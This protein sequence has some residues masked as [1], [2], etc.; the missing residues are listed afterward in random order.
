MK[1][2]EVKKPGYPSMART[3]SVRKK[4]VVKIRWDKKELPGKSDLISAD[5]VYAEHSQSCQ[6][7]LI[8][9]DML[10]SERHRDHEI[11]LRNLVK[12]KELTL[13]IYDPETLATTNLLALLLCR[14]LNYSEAFVMYK[15][16]LAACILLGSNNLNYSSYDECKSTALNNLGCILMKR[17]QIR[18]ATEHFDEALTIRSRSFADTTINCDNIAHNQGNIE[19]MKNNY[20][21]AAALYQDVLPHR[22][23]VSESRNINLC[24]TRRSFADSLYRAGKFNEAEAVYRHLLEDLTLIV[25]VRHVSLLL[26]E[27]GLAYTLLQQG[28]SVEAEAVVRNML[29]A[30]RSTVETD[31]TSIEE[32]ASILSI[33]TKTADLL[34]KQ[35]EY[36]AAEKLY[37][38]ILPH[39]QN[40]VSDSIARC[41]LEQGNLVG[42]CN[43]YEGSLKH[44]EECYGNM[45]PV[46]L[47]AVT[48]LGDL[49]SKSSNHDGALAC[50]QRA[51]EAYTKE[52]GPDNYLTLLALDNSGKMHEKLNRLYDAQISFTASLVG[53]EKTLGNNNDNQ[54]NAL[55]HV[56]NVRTVFIL[57]SHSG[58]RRGRKRSLVLAA[59][60]RFTTSFI[61]III[62]R[63]I[64]DFS[65]IIRSIFPSS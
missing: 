33:M 26:C 47:F 21:A 43:F 56:H 25:G 65:A 44:R 52:L 24:D 41:R 13:G 45:H 2:F 51:Y 34:F 17:N 61:I 46:T 22:L 10:G 53:F 14:M 62:I 1:T 55:L 38:E 64:S 3:K 58:T 32:E 5:I 59:M 23:F 42:A 48:L 50:Y 19:F 31:S 9:V 63:G 57:K 12:E 35:K 54:I 49:R 28:K 15:K 8:G 36:A 40:E 11:T 30:F 4:R 20:E 6:F 7:N 37:L 16:V 27:R 29:V 60:S 18:E 39:D